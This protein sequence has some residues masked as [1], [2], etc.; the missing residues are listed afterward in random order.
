MHEG[1]CKALESTAPPTAGSSRVRTLLTRANAPRGG[2]G[3][4]GGG[5]SL[6]AGQRG[7]GGPA[8]PPSWFS[9]VHQGQCNTESFLLCRSFLLRSDCPLASWYRER[10]MFLLEM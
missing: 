7:L 10:A 9:S 3:V 2:A 4:G 6:T 1:G 5:I 8:L